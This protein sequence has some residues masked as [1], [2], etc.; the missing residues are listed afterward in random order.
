M[1]E[2]TSRTSWFAGM[3]SPY[4]NMYFCAILRA[5]V[6]SNLFDHGVVHQGRRDLFLSRDHYPIC[7]LDAE[8]SAARGNGVQ[9][10]LDLH[11]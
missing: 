2:A 7:C 3:G 11:E 4:V 8:R 1:T 9:R 6:I 5:L 10:I